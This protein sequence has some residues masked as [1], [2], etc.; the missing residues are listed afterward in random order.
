MPDISAIQTFLKELETLLYGY[1]Y[2]CHFVFKKV[3]GEAR[4]RALGAISYD[5]FKKD[6][7]AKLG[8]RGDSGAGLRLSAAEEEHLRQKIRQLWVLLEQNFPRRATEIFG[9]PEKYVSIFWGFCYL[10]VFKNEL[11]LFEGTASD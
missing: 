2:E 4:Q 9:Y 8:Y 1:N 5:D 3:G 6:V 11:Y 7:N 10:I